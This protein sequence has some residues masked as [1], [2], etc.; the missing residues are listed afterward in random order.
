MRWHNMD[1]PDQAILTCIENSERFER[2]VQKLL[3]RMAADE[4]VHSKI[5][6][7]ASSSSP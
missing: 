3:T 1:I 2:K 4:T 7:Y 6:V 5:I